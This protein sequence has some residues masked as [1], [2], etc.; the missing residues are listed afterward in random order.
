MIKQVL[1]ETF[2]WGFIL[3]FFGYILGLVLF[4]AV[5]PS[6]LGWVIMPFGIVATLWVLIKKVR[7]NSL[8]YFLL[9]ATIWTM[10]ATILDY[11]FLV[12]L[13]KPA[14]GYYKLDVYL[15]YLLTFL[16]PLAVKSFPR[17]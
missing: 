3:W 6:L 16:L 4:M 11:F 15:Y 14:D 13:L 5:P 12:K 9:L 10:L 17:R 8:P 7:P 1:I 2:G